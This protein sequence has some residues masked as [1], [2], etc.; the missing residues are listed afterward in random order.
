M[1]LAEAKAGAN[2]K[3]LTLNGLES[4]KLESVVRETF[5]LG[6]RVDLKYRIGSTLFAINE[7]HDA[8]Y[9]PVA[10]G[11]IQPTLSP[12]NP[13]VTNMPMGIET[14]NG[15]KYLVQRTAPGG[16][17]VWI[18]WKSADG[19]V[20]GISVISN[21]CSADRSTPAGCGADTNTV[22]SVIDHLK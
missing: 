14:L 12:R 18:S 16:A 15:R 22:L 10:A 7:S 6:M 8:N 19:V 4:A 1:T 2:F 11:I 21:A 3:L 5:G 17:I 9:D 13:A 20:I